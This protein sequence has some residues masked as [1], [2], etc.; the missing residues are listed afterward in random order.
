LLV[1]GKQN[2][3]YEVGFASVIERLQITLTKLREIGAQPTARRLNASLCFF[4]RDLALLP[5][6]AVFLEI[7][8]L[9]LERLDA[10]KQFGQELFV[11]FLSC[12][13]TPT[14]LVLFCAP[15]SRS[16]SSLCIFSKLIAPKIEE[17]LTNFEHA[18]N[19]ISILVLVL[20][21]LPMQV[22]QLIIPALSSILKLYGAHTAWMTNLIFPFL[23]ALSISSR[24][25]LDGIKPEEIMFLGLM[26]EVANKA[27]G[28]PSTK[29][30]IGQPSDATGYARNVLAWSGTHENDITLNTN[31]VWKRIAWVVQFQ[32]LQL[33]SVTKTTTSLSALQIAAPLSARFLNLTVVFL[34]ETSHLVFSN[35]RV[36][37]YKLFKFI[38]RGLTESNMNI[39]I[40]LWQN[41]QGLFH[42]PRDALHSSPDLSIG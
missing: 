34:K 25:D 9:H 22:L 8:G 37:T 24:I 28:L 35:P 38:V 11:E 16:S 40:H 18:H 26:L 4:Y 10:R 29:V 23:F 15:H 27:I 39:L 2:R 33:I 12:C 41:E 1:D 7:A 21:H 6:S 17:S 19:V 32:C 20:R 14:T 42:T 36:R 31:I 30:S 5:H 13:L 3:A